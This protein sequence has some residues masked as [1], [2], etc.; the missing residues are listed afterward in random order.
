MRPHYCGDVNASNVDQEVEVCGWVNKR[1]DHGGVIFIDLR[2][3][4]GLTSTAT[5]SVLV[6]PDL[7]SIRVDT[8]NLNGTPIS[9]IQVGQPFLMRVYT[10][11]LTERG[12]G[13]FAAYTDVVYPSSL[14]TV[15][16]GLNFGADFPNT[17]FRCS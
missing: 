4:N 7:A 17:L 8:T 9:T 3:R 1:R 6:L 14:V 13:V 10:Q 2:D 16:G 15:T 11:D 12:A 5:V